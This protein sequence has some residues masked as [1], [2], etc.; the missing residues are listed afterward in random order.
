MF[1]DYDSLRDYYN[2]PFSQPKGPWP[3]ASEVDDAQSLLDDL[4]RI[5]DKLRSALMEISDITGED[6][7]E[8]CEEIFSA[9][10][11]AREEPN[12]VLAEDDEHER[13]EM[14]R[15]YWADVM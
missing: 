2:S 12:Q 15:Q 3:T 11:A 14:E 4:E 9:I 5:D 8:C 1:K 7:S 6:Y 13:R 10:N